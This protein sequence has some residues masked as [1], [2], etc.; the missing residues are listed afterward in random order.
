MGVPR[1][2]K[3]IAFLTA[4]SGGIGHVPRQF[5]RRTVCDRYKRLF[6]ETR[7]ECVCE[8]LRTV[9]VPDFID[10]ILPPE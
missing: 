10:A 5:W 8:D 1:R 2:F 6:G 4:S 7:L 3:A 9:N